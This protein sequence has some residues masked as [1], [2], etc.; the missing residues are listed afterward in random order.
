M[1]VEAGGPGRS[2]AAARVSCC[3]AVAVGARAHALHVRH[4]LVHVH[5]GERFE[6]RRHLRRNLRQ[7][8]GQLVGA[9]RA[10]AA[11]GDDGDLVHFAERLGHGADHLRHAADEA[12][13]DRGLRPFLISLGLD[14]HR[15][16]FG[17]AFLEDDRGLGFALG[18]NGRCAAFG[19]DGQARLLRGG[20]ILDALAL[21][22]RL[23][24]HGRDQLLLVAQDFGFLHF[25]LLFFLDLL[26]LHLLRDDLLLHDVGLDLVGLVR[27]RLLLAALLGELRFLDIQ[28][29]LRLG[30]LGQRLRL[31]QHALLVGSGLGD[32][33]FAQCDGAADGGIALGFGGGNIGIALDARDV[34]TAHV[35]DVV[36][37]VADF[38]DG[39][40]DHF[41]AHLAHVFR[42]GG[43]HALAHHLRLLHDL[44]DGELADDAAQVAF[45]H[46]A[47]QAFALRR[48]L[49]EEL[50]GGGEDGFAVGADLDLRDGFDGD[51]DALLGVEVLLRRDVEGHQLQRELAAAFDDRER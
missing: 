29:A 48:R 40:R 32:G 7:V 46:Q 36:V 35:G 13:D 14:V 12:I 31:G 30:L 41:E 27:L 2:R 34:R 19:F 6:E 23:F 33:G 16:R 44:L 15:L 25:D 37:L 42:A 18:A 28:I 3:S 17:L 10:L 38:L 11:G 50:L 22:L 49:G 24:Q 8:A 1:P 5:A 21:D 51:G 45:H 9:H 20:E 26:H 4:Q 43:A 39:E 47:D